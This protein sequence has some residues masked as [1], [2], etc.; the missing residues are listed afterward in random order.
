[1]NHQSVLDPGI[2]VTMLRHMESVQNFLGKEATAHLSDQKI[3][4]TAQGRSHGR[5]Q[6]EFLRNEYAAKGI[7]EV[8]VLISPAKRT[9]QTGKLIAA[10]GSERLRY[11]IRPLDDLKET[12]LV[13]REMEERALRILSDPGLFGRRIMASGDLPAKGLEAV[14]K[15][16]VT[17]KQLQAR[18]DRIPLQISRLAREPVSPKSF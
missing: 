15:G 14:L 11:E 5:V 7:S 16:L 1:M 9:T 10:A 12:C 3:L 18:L 2:T 8:L 13:P 17:T 6:A 4:L